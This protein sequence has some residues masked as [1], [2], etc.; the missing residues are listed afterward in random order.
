MAKILALGAYFYQAILAF[1][2]LI[3]VAR[4]LL[5]AEYASYSLFMAMTQFGAIF[6]F[7]WLRFACSRFY[8]GLTAETE[9]VQRRTIV[10]E[11][12]VCAVICLVGGLA[13]LPFGSSFPVALLGGAVAVCQGASDLHLSIVRFGQRFAAFSWLQGLRASFLAVGT[14][15]GAVAGHSFIA[16]IAG[17]LAAYVAYALAA[18]I[19]DRRAYAKGGIFDRVVAREHLIYGSVSAGVS[20]LA[21]LSPL[22]L[23]LILTTSLG[24]AGAAGVLLAL[25]LLQRPF[26]LIVSALQAIQYPDVV[27]AFDRKDKALPRRLGQFYALL[28]TLSLI[29]AA[30][31]FVIL[32]PVAELAVAPAMR[33]AFL[34]TGP[35]VV[36]FSMLRALTQNMSTTPAHL[37]LNLKDLTLLALADCLSFNLLAFGA[38]VVFGPAA[39]PIVAGATL[40]ATL[41]G[42]Y[43]LRIAASLPYQLP[44]PPVLIAL[45]AAAVAAGLFFVPGFTPIIG[46]LLAGIAA[47]AICLAAL[48]ALFFAL[49]RGSAGPAPSAT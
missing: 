2:L 43:G 10:V 17:T 9:L 40:G 27:A 44:L 18:V 7:E 21:L 47:G 16:A 35:L 30:G 3:A 25:D 32:R 23:K 37:V 19:I 14:V 45:L 20:V 46:A 36:V 33:E 31:I 26:T 13:T 11:A 39:L 49:R 6:S 29:T 34:L 48:L 15:G 28:I 4:L 12:L 41:A 22:G 5:P 1:G 42:L 8:P 38:T 24:P